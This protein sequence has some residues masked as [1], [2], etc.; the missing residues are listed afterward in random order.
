M[1]QANV[2]LVCAAWEAWGRRDMDALF[3]CYDRAIVWDQTRVDPS[4]LAA[5]YHGHAGVRQ[6]FRAWLGPFESYHAQAEDFIDAGERVV[7]RCRQGGRG[8]QSGVE[9][10]MASFWQVYRLEDGLIVRID[11]YRNEQ[12]ALEAV[13]LAG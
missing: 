6:F 10:E 1:S 9:V 5:E 12:A 2:E 4:E 11:V 13:G 7:V 3:A 8:K